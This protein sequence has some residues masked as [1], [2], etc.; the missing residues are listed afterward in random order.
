MDDVIFQIKNQI[1]E[2]ITLCS[3]FFK[4]INW[5]TIIAVLVGLTF[6]FFRKWE[7]KRILSFFYSLFLLMI[8]YVRLEDLFMKS[9][10]LD[11]AD[12]GVNILRV[13]STFIIAAIFLYHN[14]IVQ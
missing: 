14:S 2:T 11:A 1:Y 13:V 12:L 3:A 6:F 7:F 5:L 9:F 10:A 8:V 4:K